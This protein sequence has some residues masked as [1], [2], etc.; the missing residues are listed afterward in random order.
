VNGADFDRAR[1]L[2]LLTS[3]PIGRVVYTDQALPAVTP[4]SF[5]L[6]GEAVAILTVS[7][8]ALAVAVR[9]AVVAFQADRIDPA[10]LTGWSVTVVGR[11][12]LVEVPEDAAG[13]ASRHFIRIATRHVSGGRLA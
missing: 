5:V 4:V 3:V 7:G 6:D 10:T 1:C 2:S 9:G 8:S 11:A 13:P 12:R